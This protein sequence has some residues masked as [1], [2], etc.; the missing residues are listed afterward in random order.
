MSVHLKRHGN[1][2]TPT[3]MNTLITLRTYTM[4]SKYHTPVN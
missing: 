2:N 1:S 4:A 3:A